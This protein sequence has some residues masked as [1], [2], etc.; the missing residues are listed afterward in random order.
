MLKRFTK[1]LAWTFT[2]TAFGL[3]LR[4]WLAPDA[5]LDF[6][7]SFNYDRW[8][9]TAEVS[10]YIAVRVYQ[11]KSFWFFVAALIAACVLQWS[12]QNAIQEAAAGESR[13]VRA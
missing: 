12:R 5:C 8:E 1:V 4:T 13:D 9:C 3:F 2:V 11:L 6:G 10:E 7:G